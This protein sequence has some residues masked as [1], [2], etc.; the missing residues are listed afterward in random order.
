MLPTACAT[1][2]LAFR[3]VAGRD[4]VAQ[5]DGGTLTADGGTVRLR[6][7]DRATGLLARCA[8]CV[9][10]DRD[11]TRVTHP[12][13]A[14]VRP[15]GYGLALGNE[16]LNDPDA[17][18]RPFVDVFV[19]AH[20][21]TPPTERILNLDATADPVHGA[22]AGRCFHGDDGH[23]C[24]RP[25]SLVA[26]EHLLCARLRPADRAA[27][28]GA[29]EES[30]CASRTARARRRSARLHFASTTRRWPTCCW[31]RS[32]GSG[33]PGP[34]WRARSAPRSGSRSSGEEVAHARRSGRHDDLQHHRPA[35]HPLGRR[36][37]RAHL[38]RRPAA[39]ARRG[40]HALSCRQCVL[41][42]RR[43][44][45]SASPWAARA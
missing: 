4:V 25:L 5:C 16:D 36:S 29:L 2:S 32:V 44:R 7:T 13:E 40:A 33:S 45:W 21:T 31:P 17:V 10:K 23:S 42:K 22:Q 6:E 39:A 28:A 38:A 9:T 37:Q 1:E 8:A 20:A 27:R 30:A 24:H 12:V 26:G 18:E 43:T 34:R 19:H 3:A 35:A 11:P 41:R 15:R 14:L